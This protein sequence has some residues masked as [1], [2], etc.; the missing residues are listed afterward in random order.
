M[1][2]RGDRSLCGLPNHLVRHFDDT[3]VTAANDAAEIV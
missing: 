2:K 1:L 3:R